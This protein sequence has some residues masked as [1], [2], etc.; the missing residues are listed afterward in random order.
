MR[1]P[2]QHLQLRHLRLI[3]AIDEFGQLSIAAERL[4][5]TQPA[6]SRMLAEIESLLDKPLFV[7][8]PKGMTP[9]PIG[10]VLIR[11]T[12]SLLR[13]LTATAI[14]VD[15][16]ASGKTG[17]V[18]VGSVTGA[19]VAYVVPSVQKLLVVASDADIQ[20]SVA[21]SEQLIHGLLNGEF[22]FVLSR[23]PPPHDKRQF[24]FLQGRSETV[25]FLVRPDHPL[26]SFRSP[27]LKE[28]RSY[29]WVIQGVGTPM[30]E[31]VEQTFIEHSIPL[32]GKIIN[33]TSLLV[34]I[35]YLQNSDAI[36]PVSSEVAE[37][38]EK[39]VA[40]GMAT[41]HFP[42]PITIQPY[43]LIQKKDQI[44]SP[45]AARLRDLLIEALQF[46]PKETSH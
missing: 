10:H 31:A 1:F 9:T 45:V 40:G 34:T 29:S 17:S 28:F 26:L 20:I 21:P 36:S 42:A 43:H 30:R 24:D 6:A 23:V 35:A 16:F 8:N 25:E 13:G 7:R 4:A 3:N 2:I 41:V 14:D 38:L 39:S 37:L 19:A 18:R 27:T 33:T 46:E 15:A 5:I 32:P 44:L 11:H 22:D 12:E